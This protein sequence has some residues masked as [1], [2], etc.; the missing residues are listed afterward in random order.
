VRV[1]GEAMTRWLHR[2]LCDRCPGPCSTRYDMQL[3]AAQRQERRRLVELVA[4]GG[5]VWRER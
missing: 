2:L 4:A 5:G 1:R 3:A